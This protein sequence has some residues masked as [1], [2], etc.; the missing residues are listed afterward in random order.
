MTST[1]QSLYLDVASEPAFAVLHAAAAAR[2]TAVV[3]CPPFGF[4]EISAYR[5]LREVAA[6]LAEAGYPTLRLTLPSCGDSGGSPRDPHRLE[7]WTAAVAAA[8]RAM[9][10]LTGATAVVA[11]GLGLG[12]LVAHRAAATGAPLDGLALW[13]TPAAGKD[14]LRALRAFARLERPLFFQDRPA[15]P[16][17]P[18]GEL[19][20]G[21]FVL[22]AETVADLRALDLAALPIPAGLSRG[23]LL[24]DRDGIAGD[25]RLADALRG[26]GIAVTEGSGEG[27][28]A[29]IGHPQRSEVPEAVVERLRGWLHGGSR[30]A[31]GRAA[32]PVA[33]TPVAGTPAGGAAVAGT[34]VVEARMQ[35]PDGPVHETPVEIVCDGVGLAGVLARA[36]GHRHPV[37]AVFLHSGSVRRVGPNR[38]WV[39]AARRWAAR[40][41]VASL[42]LDIEGIGDAGGPVAPYRTDGPLH[43]PRLLDQ[44]RAAVD[45]LQRRGI[46]DRAVFCGL[47]SGAYWSLH[48]ALDDPRVVGALL[49]NP[50]A[51]VYDAG[52]GPARDLRRLLD[53]PFDVARLRRAA[54]R[55]RMAEMARWVAA[56]PRRSLAR[57]HA[58]TG[59][60][61]PARI[62]RLLS[63]L[64]ESGKL[65][66]LAFADNEP[67]E[68]E[69]IASGWLQRIAR[70]PQ[71][72]VEHLP[73]RDHTLRPVVSQRWAHELLERALVPVLE[74]A[75]AVAA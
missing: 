24:L 55:Q 68:E 51:L 64:E 40:H 30:I 56:T 4:E 29:L 57:R 31:D 74:A 20:A 1:T 39:E 50:R 16:P 37:A 19:E 75:P 72:T 45:E 21:G 15:P 18:E 7:T 25:G 23:A 47:C 60:A 10:E 27:Y 35:T 63:E 42:R 49:V 6:R 62:E 8:A 71:A 69:L 43:E 59:P 13:A 11:F 52:L 9:R 70:W 33:G 73:V 53:D 36:P 61:V 2:D 32:A 67:L 58:G 65:R 22:S 14:L 38:M 41:G 66:A 54:S 12:G 3:I 48:V 5:S 17:P 44:V 26:Q 34:P 28:E 46:A